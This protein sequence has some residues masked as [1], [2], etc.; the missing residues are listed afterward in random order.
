MMLAY[1]TADVGAHHNRA[2]VLGH[3]VAGAW[4]SVHDLIASGGGDKAQPK[5]EISNRSAEYVIASQHTR[6]LFDALGNCRLQMMEL[7]FEEEP[8][9]ELYSLITGTTRSW[10]NLL[11]ISERIWQLTR[12]FSVREIK[13]FGRHLDF[14]PARLYEDPIAD[15]PNQ[16]HVISKEDI[17]KLLTWYYSARGWSENGIPTRETLKSAGLAEVVEEFENKGLLGADD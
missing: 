8:Y 7:G 4:T 10:Q 13:G 9:A 12:A 1:M 2:W 14:P 16:G 6:S 15:G 3:D 11:E 5:A 17:N